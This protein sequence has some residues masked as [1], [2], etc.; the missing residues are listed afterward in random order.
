MRRIRRTWLVAALA[1]G[2]LAVAPAAQ[3]QSDTDAVLGFINGGGSQISGAADRALAGEELTA[4]QIEALQRM[5][6]RSAWVDVTGAIQGV[7]DQIDVDV[8]NSE[9][10]RI[11]GYEQVDSNGQRWRYSAESGGWV[12]VDEDP[13]THSDVYTPGPHVPR[14]QFG[15]SSGSIYHSMRQY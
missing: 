9:Q 1:A 5:T 10:R 8:R 11:Y 13:L 7:L 15:P 4:E 12:K 6:D 3:A 14:F 2:S